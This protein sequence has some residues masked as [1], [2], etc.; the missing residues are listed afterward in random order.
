[1]KKSSRSKSAKRR[2][3]RMDSKKVFTPDI[4]RTNLL[5][6]SLYITS[7]EILKTAIVEGLKDFF[8]S[9]EPPPDD[10][11]KERLRSIDPSLVEHFRDSYQEEVNEYEKEVG[12]KLDDRDKLGLMPSCKWLQRQNVLSEDEVDDIRKI[13]DHRNEIAHELPELLIGEGFDIQVEH[14]QKIRSLIHKIDVFWA[15]SDVFFD[16]NSLDEVDVQDVPD[17]QIVSGRDAILSLITDTVVD[18]L[19]EIIKG[20]SNE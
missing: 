14:F 12:I 3:T 5:L 11:L 19:N 8:I 9:Q 13:R 10:N 4:L 6:S 7:F 15:R 1:M 2:E 18:Y 16:I 20:K 17:D